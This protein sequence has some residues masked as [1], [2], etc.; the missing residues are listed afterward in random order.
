MDTVSLPLRKS[1]LV[2]IGSHPYT[3]LEI[4]VRIGNTTDLHSSPLNAST[5]RDMVQKVEETLLLEE[6]GRSTMDQNPNFVALM[7]EYEDGVLLYRIEQDEVWQKLPVNDSLQRAYFAGHREDYR[8]PDRV[9]FAEIFVP[10]DSLAKFCAK[11]I[12]SGADFKAIAAKYSTRPGYAEKKG[13][14]GLL[15]T[16]V[17][18][19]AQRAAR[20]GRDSVSAPFAYQGGWSIVK[21]LDVDGARLK[22]YEEALP[23]VSSAYQDVAAKKR[24]QEWVDLLRARYS[25]HVNDEVLRSAFAGTAH[26]R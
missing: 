20:L 1:V 14:W 2:T 26:A 5:V 15:P 4:L 3:V 21:N 11:K 17:N 6:H 8:W 7:K 9:N 22:T 25:V 16:T 13:E 18:D 19:L 23:E 24:E 10:T 12:R